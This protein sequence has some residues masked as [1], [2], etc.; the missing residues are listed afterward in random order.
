MEGE[1]NKDI[2]P[3]LHP[4]LEDVENIFWFYLL[5]NNTLADPEVQQILKKKGAPY[6]LSMLDRYNKWVNLKIE[7][8]YR[9]KKYESKMNI[10]SSSIL[11][12]KAMT[13]IMYELLKSSEYYQELKHLEEFQFLRHIRNGAAHN[14]RFNLKNKRDEWLIEENKKIKW[15]DGDME[16]TRERQETAVFNNFISFSGIFLLANHF[17]KKLK[18][19]DGNK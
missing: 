4:L 17:S 11:I 1:N 8:D 6:L 12:G 9:N 5:S 19:I 2:P 14:N 10:L 13:I 18:E 16:I 3:K 7:I 15:I